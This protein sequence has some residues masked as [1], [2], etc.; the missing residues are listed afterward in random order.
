LKALEYDLT[1]EGNGDKH[2]RHG[3]GEC[4]LA[5]SYSAAGL[6]KEEGQRVHYL[7]GQTLFN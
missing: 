1:A 5:L 2:Q 3:Q 7:I 6:N 4:H